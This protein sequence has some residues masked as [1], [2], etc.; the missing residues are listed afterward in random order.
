[1]FPQRQI[2]AYIEECAL[3][4]RRYQPAQRHFL[5]KLRD[6]PTNFYGGKTKLAKQSP[7]EKLQNLQFLLTFTGFNNTVMHL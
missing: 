6:S 7:L 1:V 2:S 3:P 4:K 5:P